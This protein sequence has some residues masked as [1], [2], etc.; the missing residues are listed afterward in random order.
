MSDEL[1]TRELTAQERQILKSCEEIIEQGLQTIL[2]KFYVVGRALMTIR[3][4]R[5]YRVES[6]SFHHYVRERWDMSRR[7]ADRFIKATQV[8]DQ[9]APTPVMPSR[10]SQIRPLT[11]LPPDRWQAA[12]EEAV[13]AAHGGPVTARHVAA[14]VRGTPVLPKPRNFGESINFRGLK[15]APIN[16]QGV[17][18]LFGMV[19]SELGFEVESVQQAFYDCIAKR[20][21]DKR[22]RLFREV[23]IE[24]EFQSRNFLAHAH[25]PCDLIVCWEHNW[26]DCPHE[27]VELKTAIQTLEP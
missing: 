3:D 26:P 9:I 17:V 16:E 12:W 7:S 22:R 24:L 18:F 14:I 27:V 11:K 8:F 10:E 5:L 1:A 13:A 4:E 6:A 25:P 15:R 20:C 23:R 21:I 19:S 2:E